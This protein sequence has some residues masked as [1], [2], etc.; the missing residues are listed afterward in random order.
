M[1]LALDGGPLAPPSSYRARAASLPD[2]TGRSPFQDGPVAHFR[3]P[4]Q[5]VSW[6]VQEV[7][8]ATAKAFE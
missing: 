5:R 6:T 3:H 8:A 4:S 7:T 2:E 1:A